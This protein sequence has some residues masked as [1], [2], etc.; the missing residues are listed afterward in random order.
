MDFYILLIVSV[1][2]IMKAIQRSIGGTVLITALILIELEVVIENLNKITTIHSE[3]PMKIVASITSLIS[4][5][6]NIVL[7]LVPIRFR[8]P[9]F[10]IAA[11]Y[12]S[13]VII[14][15][16]YF[17][18]KILAKVY[19]GV[20]AASIFIR[21]LACIAMCLPISSKLSEVTPFVERPTSE[22]GG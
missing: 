19:V 16:D 7:L 10:I 8:I 15:G 22:M 18:R 9:R 21:V 12:L 1:P 20:V 5:L 17:I 11:I 4:I 6:V 13:T 3:T 2:L 14:H